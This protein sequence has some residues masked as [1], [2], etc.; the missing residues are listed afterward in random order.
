MSHLV[1]PHF[2][3]EHQLED[4]VLEGGTKV[5]GLNVKLHQGRIQVLKKTFKNVFFYFCVNGN[6]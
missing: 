6:F 5:G 4:L 3:E 1:A 2:L